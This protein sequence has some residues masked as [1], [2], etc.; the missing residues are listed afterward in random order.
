MRGG[1]KFNLRGSNTITAAAILSSFLDF[2]ASSAS[3]SSASSS[4]LI[5]ILI[6]IKTKS[7]GIFQNCDQFATSMGT[8]KP[9]SVDD[10]LRMF[11]H[12]TSNST[13]FNL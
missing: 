12:P 13:R 10:E 1:G 11:N 5:F 4:V 3:A 9:R 6:R 2:S 8:F 7:D